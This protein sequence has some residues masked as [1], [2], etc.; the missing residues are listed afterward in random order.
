MPEHDEFDE[1]LV[2]RLRAYESRIPEGEIPMT[3]APRSGSRIS[4]PAIAAVTVVGILAGVLL[5]VVLLNRPAAPVGESSPTPTISSAAESSPS[6]ASSASPPAPPPASSSPAAS[7]PGESPGTIVLGEQGTA[8]VAASGPSGAVILGYEDAGPTAWHSRDGREWQPA[9]VP[10]DGTADLRPIR[11]V[12]SDLGYVAAMANCLTECFGGELWYSA[13]GMTW[14]DGPTSLTGGLLVHLAAGGPGFVA[15]AIDPYAAGSPGVTPTVLVSNDGLNWEAGQPPELE[16]SS[17]QALSSVGDL[18]VAVGT[19]G[20]ELGTLDASWTTTD[21]LSWE[22][23]EEDSDRAAVLD[24]AWNGTELLAVGH[25]SC[26]DGGLG[27]Q[28][29]GEANIA[30]HSPDGRTWQPALADPCCSGLSSVAATATGW[31]AVVTPDEPGTDAPLALAGRIGEAEWRIVELEADGELIL[32]S[33]AVHEGLALFVGEVRQGDVAQPVV[34][35]LDGPL[36]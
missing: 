2:Q 23:H 35:V 15:I 33:V 30:W 16:A 21:G 36:P 19:Q 6:A 17:I 9:N 5:A 32:E 14:A 27:G 10:T 7:P 31:V 29:P 22:R 34:I 26:P 20:I 3:D 24:L 25:G 12:A 1:R 4:G 13:D 8:V 28:C 18:I 11:V